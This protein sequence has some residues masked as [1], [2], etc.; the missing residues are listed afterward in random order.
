MDH[1]WFHSDKAQT[2]PETNQRYP[3]KALET[4]TQVTRSIQVK[5]HDMTMGQFHIGFHYL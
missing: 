5:Q 3:L 4:K 2:H 1:S